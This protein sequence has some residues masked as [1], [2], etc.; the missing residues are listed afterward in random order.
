MVDS[1]KNYLRTEKTIIDENGVVLNQTTTQVYR[2]NTEPNF[3]KLYLDT[4]STFMGVSKNLNPVLIELAKCMSYAGGDKYGGQVVYLNSVQKRDIAEKLG[5]K[6]DTVT[7]AIKN[8]IENKMIKR[9]ARETYQ[10]N[11]LIF[12][13]GDWKDII[14]IRADIDFNAGIIKTEIQ[15]KPQLEQGAIDVEAE[16]IKQKQQFIEQHLGQN[17]FKE[18]E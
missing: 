12:G 11:P 9:V 6:V 5:I 16:E 17:I 1:K 13:K 18:M 14:N 15:K 8:L 7:H 3:I 4:L 2:T 10:I